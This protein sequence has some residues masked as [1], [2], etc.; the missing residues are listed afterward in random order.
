M[1]SSWTAHP[2]LASPRPP[3]SATERHPSYSWHGQW[4][5]RSVRAG[6]AT[7]A[8]AG[9]GPWS[10]M[11]SPASPSSWPVPPAW[12]TCCAAAGDRERPALGPGRDLCRGRLPG[13]HRHRSAGHG[14]PA[15]PGDRRAQ[16]GWAGQ[17]GRRAALSQPRPCPAPCHPGNQPRMRPTSR[18]I[19]GALA[20][21]QLE[22]VAEEIIHGSAGLKVVRDGRDHR[23]MPLGELIAV[24]PTKRVLVWRG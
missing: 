21:D 12:P 14:R 3:R 15:Q 23:G 24:E 9:G 20:Q 22:A 11:R 6:S 2:L 13:P 16:L 5:S 8:P 18:H 19:A 1:T 10:S 4:I 17:P 7:L